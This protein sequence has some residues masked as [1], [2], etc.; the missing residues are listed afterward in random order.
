MKKLSK[1]SLL[2][3]LMLCLL[4]FTGNGQEKTGSDTLLNVKAESLPVPVKEKKVR[5]NSIMVTVSNPALISSEFKTFGYERVLPHNQSVTATFGKFSIPKFRGDLAD[6]LGL[7]TDYKDKG[8][9]FSTD[10]RF[11]L[12]KENRNPAPRGVYIAPFY[13]Y[14]HLNRENSWILET[15]GRIDEVYTTLKLNIHTIGAELGY[16][17]VF[18]DRVALDLILLGPGFGF[19]GV[20]TKLGTTLDPEKE[21]EF[22]D[23]LN[24]ILADKIPGYEKVIEPGDF[25]KSGTYNTQSVGFRYLI[26][27]GYRF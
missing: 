1:I 18:W 7:N 26:R 25:S 24:Q 9:H 6:S 16:Q 21:S 22:F 13:T 17:F 23:K 12:M 4:F 20:K 3:T 27:I 19:Y 14:N 8:F 5:K 11:Y 2:M 15:D 10:Y